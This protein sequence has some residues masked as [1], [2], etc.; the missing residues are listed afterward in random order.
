MKQGIHIVTG[1][2]AVGK[3]TWALEWAETH[4]A[5]IVSCDSLL[6]YRGMDIGT[7]K[8]PAEE[9]ARIPHHLI[10]INPV[11]Q[12]LN[13][14]AYHALAR[15]A[16]KS[17][18][19]RGRTV[20]VTGG[21]GFY[22]KSFYAPVADAWAPSPVIRERVTSLHAAEG[23]PGL[24]RALNELNPEGLGALDTHNPRRVIRAL[25]RCLTSGQSLLTMLANFDSQPPPFAGMPL[26]VTLLQR[27]A[28]SLNQRIEQR[29]AAMLKAGL[30]DEVVRLKEEGLL[31]NPS[32]A[33]AIGYRETLAY[34]EGQLDRT[35]LEA[36]I[37]RNTRQLV[38][39][40]RKWF[41]H[42]LPPHQIINLK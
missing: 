16:V 22:L 13:V 9:Q 41:R 20:L 39:K 3:T 10:D 37:N 40:Q 7:A 32:A 33:Q 30:I 42:Q 18:L 8:P 5:E 6:V 26:T 2:T 34:L 1:P 23:L 38:A 36:A 28:E 35:S 17:I 29:T 31:D 14:S 27:P 4:Q 25:E 12:P 19:D 24:L 15:K 11:S 21:S